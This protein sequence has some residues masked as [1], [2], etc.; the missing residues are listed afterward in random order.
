M[1]KITKKMV[2]N[3]V[4]NSVN[5]IGQNKFCEIVRHRLAKTLSESST[6]DAND[7]GKISKSTGVKYAL[8]VVKLKR[9]ISKFIWHLHKRARVHHRKNT[10]HK[11]TIEPKL[12]CGCKILLIRRLRR[13][14]QNHMFRVFSAAAAASLLYLFHFSICHFDRL[15]T[16]AM[17][18]LCQHQIAV[19][20]LYRMGALKSCIIYV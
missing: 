20:R 12:N 11:S 8:I 16:T 2:N 18:V 6:N 13:V 9:K 17:A 15:T 1:D 5:W 10:K 19:Y 4:C 14:L 3:I 7:D